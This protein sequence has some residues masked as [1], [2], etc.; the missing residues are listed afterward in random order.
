[1]FEIFANDVRLVS[2]S[3]CKNGITTLSLHAVNEMRSSQNKKAK[4][5]L[6]NRLNFN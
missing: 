5:E 2:I 6:T 1:M 3:L 4:G